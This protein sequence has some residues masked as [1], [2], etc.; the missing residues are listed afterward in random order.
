MSLKLT[1][2]KI[3]SYTFIICL[4][5]SC[6]RPPYNN[7][8]TYNR[9]GKRVAVDSGVGAVAGA[10]I[11]GTTV[12]TLLGGGIGGTVG[13]AASFSRDSKKHIVKE[14]KKQDIQ[15]VQYGDTNLL[16][17]PT[18]KYFMFLSP[19]LNELCYPGLTNIVRLLKFYPYSTIYVAGFTDNVGSKRHKNKI[20]QAQA[21]TIMTYLW[22]NGIADTRLKAEGYGDKNPISDNSIIHGSAQNRRIEIEWFNS[23]PKPRQTE[24]AYVK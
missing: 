7:F 8:K 14:L 20:S 11:A 3:L 10:V 12:G 13:L 2:A 9:A 15:Y 23:P 4:L 24:V 21:E 19:R 16:I 22:S 5:A 18:D 1:I 17:I 6:F